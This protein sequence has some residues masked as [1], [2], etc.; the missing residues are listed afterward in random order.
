[1][2]GSLERQ[3][4]VPENEWIETRKILLKK[5]KEFTVLRSQMRRELPW[6]EVT[7]PSLFE[8]PDRLILD[9]VVAVCKKDG[10]NTKKR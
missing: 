10:T 5:E 3:K 2:I 8:G 9:R 4:A 1:M 7:K 6:K